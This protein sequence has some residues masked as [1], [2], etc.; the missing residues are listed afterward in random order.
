MTKR[1]N[2]KAKKRATKLKKPFVGKKTSKGGHK[3]AD[4]SL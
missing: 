2:I 4:I 3:F 1:K